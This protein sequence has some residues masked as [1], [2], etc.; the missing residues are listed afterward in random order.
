MINGLM[1]TCPQVER[2]VSPL[3]EGGSHRVVITSEEQFKVFTLPALKPHHKY[4]L[5][6]HEG[7]RVRAVSL[8]NCKLL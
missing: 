2:G 3:P 1:A 8:Y 4:K 6:A 5:T 7:A